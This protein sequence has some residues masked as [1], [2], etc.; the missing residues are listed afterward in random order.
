MHVTGCDVVNVWGFDRRLRCGSRM[1][2]N[3]LRAEVEEVEEVEG[4]WC[5]ERL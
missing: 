5:L 2:V 4:I 1:F 3:C